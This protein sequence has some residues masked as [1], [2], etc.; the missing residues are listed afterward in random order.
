MAA[1]GREKPI[2]RIKR[3]RTGV[4]QRS[5][6]GEARFE[7]PSA[8]RWFTEEVILREDGG[9]EK[10]TYIIEDSKRPKQPYK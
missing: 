5:Q 4:L 2:G 3:Q 6:S 9:D 8:R 7:S 10:E 1:Q